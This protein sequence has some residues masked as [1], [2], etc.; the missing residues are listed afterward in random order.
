[1]STDEMS[2]KSQKLTEFVD[3]IEYYGK[4]DYVNSKTGD[5]L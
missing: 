4:L 2:E 1:M 5:F 3:I